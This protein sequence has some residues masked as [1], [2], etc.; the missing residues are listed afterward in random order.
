M[1]EPTP[2]P[3]TPAVPEPTSD[4]PTV[5]ELASKVDQIL[6]ILGGGKDE[7]EGEVEPPSV[8]AEVQR[9][10]TRLRKAEEAKAERD[11]EKAELAELKEKVK[12]VAEKQPR[13]YRR[14]TRFMRWTDDDE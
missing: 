9:E 7:G 10:L 4:E 1:S 12:R 2:E 11:A 3:E 5:K 6:G 14:S 8:K 13:E